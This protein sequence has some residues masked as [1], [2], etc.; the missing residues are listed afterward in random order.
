MSYSGNSVLLKEFHLSIE[1]L[2]IISKHLQNEMVRGLSNGNERSSLKMLPS[3]VNCPTGQEKGVFYALDLGGTN[4]R[5]LRLELMGNGKIGASDKEEFLI[6]KEAMTGNADQLFDFIAESVLRFTM[7]HPFPCQQETSKILLGFTFSF[8]VEQTSLNSGTLIHWTKGFQT[9]G[10]EGN[11]VVALLNKAFSNKH[12]PA[13]VVALANDTVG[14]LVSHCYSYQDTAMGVIIGT[15]TNACYLEEVKNIQKF[16]ASSNSYSFQHMIIN[17]EWG[18]FGES[19]NF[20]PL[21]SVDCELD[22]DSVNCGYQLFEKMI[23]G[24]YLG[25]IARR[26]LVKLY[27]SG[28]FLAAPPRIPI[29]QLRRRNLLETSLLAKLVSDRSGE[30][31]VV[32]DAF[33]QS[34]NIELSN[35]E[36]RRLVQDTARIVI[37]RSAQLTATAIGAVLEKTGRLEHSKVAIDGSVFEHIPLFREQLGFCLKQLYPSSEI[38]LA[39]SKDGS[40]IGAAIIAAIAPVGNQ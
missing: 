9:S 32:R 22:Q 19:S 12:V 40:G 36:D 5:V 13:E 34:M 21:T 11:D 33:Y 10:V 28:D 29:D 25:E 38:R 15:G 30:L 17:M 39:L 6:S 27:E 8:P 23:S 14:T 16:Q 35:L 7:K 1:K 3:Y 4:F 24:M 20:L 37:S 31:S 2:K 18:A 26:I